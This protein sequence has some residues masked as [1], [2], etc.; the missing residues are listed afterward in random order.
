MVYVFSF[1]S[2]S[3]THAS[4]R[5]PAMSGVVLYLPFG[6]RG[7]NAAE[8]PT[9]KVD[10]ILG[11]HP[12]SMIAVPT[13]DGFTLT[14]SKPE[15]LK[16][17]NN[18]DRISPAVSKKDEKVLLGDAQVPAGTSPTSI[19]QDTEPRPVVDQKSPATHHVQDRLNSPPAAREPQPKESHRVLTLVDTKPPGLKDMLDLLFQEHLAQLN[20]QSG[21]VLAEHKKT[22]AD[23]NAKALNTINQAADLAERE[24]ELALADVKQGRADLSR[25]KDQAVSQV[26]RFIKQLQDERVGAEKASKSLAEAV[27]KLEE[28]KSKCMQKLESRYNDANQ[29]AQK[30]TNL[31]TTAGNTIKT[32]ERNIKTAEDL[33]DNVLKK[34]NQVNED[35]Q[36][37]I[38][39]AQAKVCYQYKLLKNQVVTKQ[40]GLDDFGKTL[41]GMTTK[42]EQLWKEREKNLV[43][44]PLPGPCASTIPSPS[45]P[46]Y[47]AVSD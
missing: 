41:E 7:K 6:P 38:N 42:L 1:P 14:F 9:V 30:A 34:I 18:G 11:D 19:G 33:A 13:G 2:S 29:Q 45:T 32:A 17:L 16:P 25:S 10:V 27:K 12:V 21:I 4:I 36:A 44:S 15:V 5:F 23:H 46:E 8:S 28:A 26:T 37:T 31:C 24:R 39:N 22:L 43:K 47:R 20:R 35:A 40:A 3:L